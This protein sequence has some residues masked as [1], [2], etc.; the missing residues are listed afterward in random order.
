VLDAV[1]E[2]LFEVL[3]HTGFRIEET[4]RTIFGKVKEV[5][6]TQPVIEGFGEESFV[7]TKALKKDGR[8]L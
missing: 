3:K 4:W 7:V 1:A 5:K 2:E 8:S 6:E